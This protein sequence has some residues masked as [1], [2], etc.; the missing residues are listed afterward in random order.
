MRKAGGALSSCSTGRTRTDGGPILRIETIGG[1]HLSVGD[2]PLPLPNRKAR[3][4]LAYLAWSDAGSVARDRLASLLWSDVD[5]RQARN[6]LRQV[7]FDLRASLDMAGCAAVTV[8]RDVVALAPADIELDF[9]SIL[10]GLSEGRLAPR[11]LSDPDIA[12]VLLSGYDDVSPMFGEWLATVRRVAFERLVRA[13]EQG[14]DA[15]DRPARDRRRYAEVCFRLDPMHEAACRAVMRLAAEEGEIAAA[16]RAYA[17][18]YDALGSDLDMEPSPATQALVADIKRGVPT[19]L[20]APRVAEPGLLSQEGIPVLAVLPFRTVGGD[21]ATGSFAEGLAEE[22]VCV[23]AGLREPVVI[24]SG[25]TRGVQAGQVD[26]ALLGRQLGARYFVNGTVRMQDGDGRVSVELVEAASGVVI[27]GRRYEVERHQ[28]LDAQDEIAASIAHVLAPRVNETELRL[29]RRRQPEDLGAYQLL[30]QARELIF[31]L[32][33]TAFEQAGAMLRR[34]VQLDPHY[35]ALH[36]ALADWHSLRM[37]QGWSKNAEADLRALED[38]VR[39][40]LRYDPGNARALA[41]LGHNRTLTARRYDEALNLFDRA[42][43]SGPNEAEVWMWSSPTYAYIGQAGEAMRRAER[44]IALSPHDPF[45]FRYEHFCCIAHYAAGNLE[46][47]A[48][49]GRQSIA[50]NPNYTSNLRMT[51]ASLAGMGRRDDAKAIARSV[52]ALEPGFRVGPLIARQAFRDPVER[53]RYGSRLVE[54]GLPW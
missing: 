43:A 31:R 53:E 49:W 19:S 46:A 29:S 41:M 18:L 36:V 9:A 39:A 8:G 23:L 35:P 22:I 7:L 27:W 5:E 17:T 30:L 33:P 20:D 21:A 10:S 45:L 34:A 28:R 1:L 37:F 38:S 6:S 42:L 32:E 44:A 16:L 14:Y 51:A 47:A 2:A 26:L 3:A 50:R 52:L 48:N 25:S 11:L 54:A 13:L 15:P 40:A 12:T 4:M 24:S